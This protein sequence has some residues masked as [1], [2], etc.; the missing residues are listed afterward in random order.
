MYPDLITNLFLVRS[1]RCSPSSTIFS[2]NASISAI[3]A[4]L[5]FCDFLL[6]E[7]IGSNILNWA[8]DIHIRCLM[9]ERLHINW[10]SRYF[11]SGN[12][13]LLSSIAL[14]IADNTGTFE[15]FRGLDD[16]SSTL[17]SFRSVDSLA[18]S[19]SLTMAPTASILMCSNLAVWGLKC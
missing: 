13:K 5:S 3:M 6:D 14:I 2:T 8:V 11:P 9:E 18:R 7:I 17:M 15:H 4:T 12:R 19:H 1:E 10:Q 16:V